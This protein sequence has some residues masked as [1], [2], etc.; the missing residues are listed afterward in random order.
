M[1]RRRMPQSSENVD[2]SKCFVKN[3][4]SLNIDSNT[5]TLQSTFSIWV[6]NVAYL[7]MEF[8][9]ESEVLEEFQA[10]YQQGKNPEAI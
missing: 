4:S 6:R 5:V 10:K 2:N 7:A 3:V 1:S 8:K 9:I